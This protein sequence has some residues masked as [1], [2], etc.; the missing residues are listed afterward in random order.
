M[1]ITLTVVTLV[2][3]FTAILIALRTLRFRSRIALD[4]PGSATPLRES[5]A[6]PSSRVRL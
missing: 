4:D 2:V 1:K 3:G 5:G 6:G